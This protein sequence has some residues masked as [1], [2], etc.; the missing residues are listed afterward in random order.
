MLLCVSNRKVTNDTRRV[1]SAQG[2]RCLLSAVS[3][4]GI[5][6]GIRKYVGRKYGID[7][8]GVQGTCN[9]FDSARQAVVS[10]VC[11]YG[12]LFVRPAVGQIRGLSFFFF[13]VRVK[14]SRYAYG[15]V[16]S[17]HNVLSVCEH[18]V[19]TRRIDSIRTI[20]VFGVRHTDVKKKRVSMEKKLHV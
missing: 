9:T 14:S 16:I 8:Q 15:I 20:R 11:A 7:C 12:L 17:I 5:V 13:F 3:P 10:R 1:S 19:Y 18:C 2:S 4:D 6:V